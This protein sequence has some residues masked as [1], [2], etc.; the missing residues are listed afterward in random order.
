MALTVQLL[1]TSA[2]DGIHYIY[3]LPTHMTIT[4]YD[5]SNGPPP[6]ACGATAW[7][8]YDGADGSSVGSGTMSSS[9]TSFNISNTT[10]WIGGSTIIP[11]WYQI[12]T[13]NASSSSC[14]VNVCPDN[15]LA[16]GGTN[17]VTGASIP[18]SLDAGGT[19]PG[20]SMSGWAPGAPN[21]DCYS[22]PLLSGSQLVSNV[23]ADNYFSGGSATRPHDIWI[24]S[25]TQDP[26]HPT[27]AE[28]AAAATSLAG[29]GHTGVVWEVPTN[30]PENSGYSTT[31]PATALVT[32]INA[33]R[34]AIHA[35]DS[36]ARIMVFCSAGFDSTP[37][38]DYAG[39]LAG[40][41]FVPD[42]FSMHMED[43]E[44]NMA[45]FVALRQYFDGLAAISAAAQGQGW[46]FTETAIPDVGFGVLS[47]HRATRSR[48]LFDM[49]IEQYGWPKEHN[50]YFV[51]YDHQTPSDTIA[52]EVESQPFG[53]GNGN[54]RPGIYGRHVM[55]EALFGTSVPPAI[56]N[57]GGNNTVGGNNFIG[58]HYSGT[59]WDCVMLMTNGIIGASVILNVPT[60]TIG[61]TITY[62]DGW[63]RSNTVSVDS[64]K[65]ITI[66]TSDLATYVFLPTSSTVS[67][68]DTDQGVISFNSA[69]NKIAAATV[70]NSVSGGAI[71]LPNDSF[72]SN[73]SLVAPT[74]PF[75]DGATFPGAGANG[76][77]VAT[78]T[79]S[80]SVNAP[81]AGFPT[82][83]TLIADTA[84]PGAVSPATITYSG[85]NSTNFLNCTTTSGSG[86]LFSNLAMVVTP[87]NVPDTFTA[88][89]VT[90][91]INGFALR[92]TQPTFF[93]G[94]TSYGQAPAAPTAF[95]LSINGT[96]VFNYAN[97]TAV[98]HANRPSG[99]STVGDAPATSTEYWNQQ[100]S[101][102]FAIA[103]VAVTGSIALDITATSYGGTILDSDHP[104]ITQTITI[105]EFQ[106]FSGGSTSASG[107][108]SVFGMFF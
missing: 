49:V 41:T 108:V 75:L 4:S 88:T 48:V 19:A 30:E 66:P 91:T 90:G 3:S 107:H 45:D 33:I 56:L 27:P 10:S 39:I 22:I 16:T 37:F 5:A 59:S 20:V 26:V 105:S 8:A 7:T 35:V 97:A 50:Y 62:W 103:P 25:S 42:F 53:T 12:V 92:T 9:A 86:Q 79:G 71:T 100:W 21:R 98:N 76:L 64:S 54:V 69:T 89:G 87:P 58:S 104:F 11:G 102:I 6:I 83:G 31:P 85:V 32:Q 34:S 94:D 38:S 43:F 78:L 18:T 36:T 28:Y 84:G 72:E 15:P 82:S 55:G 46:W 95:T 63:G 51:Q 106:V 81:T 96:L 14:Y 60:E 24:A 99:D 93:S 57:F 29:A 80:Q 47:T 52:Y 1:C 2:F 70:T 13:N 17:L 23:A 44:Q 101:W 74:I 65:N 68:V 77:N 67:V 40:L 61:N 73:Y